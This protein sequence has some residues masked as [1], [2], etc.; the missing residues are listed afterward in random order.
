VQS[1]SWTSERPR[2]RVAPPRLELELDLGSGAAGGPHGSALERAVPPAPSGSVDPDAP[3]APTRID[4]KPVV[5]Q[6]IE[7]HQAALVGRE[8]EGVHQLRVACR[9]LVVWHAMAERR[10]L[11]DD[12]RWLRRAAGEVRD[13]DVLL[14][15]T[16][17]EELVPWLEERR[18]QAR[19][20]LQ[21]VLDSGRIRGLLEALR[22]LEP[23]RVERVALELVRQR[24]KV[25]RLAAALERHEDDPHRER[26]KLHAL[27][28]A[29][30]GLRYT[31][32]WVDRRPKRLERLQAALGGLNDLEQ[33][34]AQL[35][36][37]PRPLEVVEL[38]ADVEARAAASQA[39][40][41]A[42]WEEARDAVLLL[43][44]EE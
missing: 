37:F 35:E 40:C 24:R 1:P 13:L 5:S 10:T 28:R 44:V 36:A 42:A 4:P 41:C 33:L 23:I 31:L 9:R 39:A 22:W 27:R 14:V 26:V 11:V 8:A 16:L 3:A 30:R 17:P 34:L 6:L 43:T 15:R 20:R 19:Q 2:S 38:V 25:A 32:A 12:L 21:T 18:A 29:L 7:A